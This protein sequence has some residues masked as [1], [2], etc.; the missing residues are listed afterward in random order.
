MAKGAVR[1]ARAT[2]IC[3]LL[4]SA[5]AKDWIGTVA[6]LSSTNDGKGVLAVQL[7]DRVTLSTTN[8]GFSESLSDLKTLIPVGSAVQTQAMALHTGQHVRFS[9][10]FAHSHDDCL[11][12]ASLTVDGSMSNPEFLF[13]FSD[14]QPAD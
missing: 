8:N 4:R 5:Q 7:S 1:P 2:A 13:R 12:E 11:E 6:T 10:N 3:S 9:G 14:V